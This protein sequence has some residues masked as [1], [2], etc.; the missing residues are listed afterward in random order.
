MPKYI[1]VYKVWLLPSAA[2]HERQLMILH[3]DEG[4]DVCI[5]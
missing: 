3:S 2:E 1:N 5:K 4:L